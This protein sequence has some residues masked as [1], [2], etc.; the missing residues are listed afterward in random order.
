MAIPP[1]LDRHK[2]LS[3]VGQ[4]FVKPNHAEKASE[5]RLENMN[6]LRLLLPRSTP[7]ENQTT[8]GL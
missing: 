8:H 7:V 3:H 5:L 1:E 6:N 2:T 4:S